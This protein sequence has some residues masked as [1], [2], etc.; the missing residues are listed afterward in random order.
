[1]SVAAA[2]ADVLFVDAGNC[3]GPGDGSELDP[4]C[5]IQTAIDNAVDA[6]EIVVAPGTYFEAIDYLGKSVAIRSSDGPEVTTIDG[7][8]FSSVVRCTHAQGPATALSGFVITGGNDTG[9]GGMFI[10]LSSPTVSDCTFIGNSAGV[11]GGM[12]NLVDSS[13][14]V[15]NCILWSDSPDEFGGAGTVTVSYSDVQGGFPGTGNIGADPLFVDPDNGD[16]RLQ[17]GSPCIDAGDNTAVPQGVL[18]DLDGNPRF[19]ADACAGDNGATVDMGAYE[20]QGTSCDLSD[21]LALLVAWGSC[22]DCGNCPS[23][24]DGDCSVGVFDLMILLADRSPR[25]SQRGGAR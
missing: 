4:Y 7:S 6:D 25:Q 16:Y 23:D 2:Q 11:G 5:S 15:T 18:R 13:L 20:F 19:V 24:H 8:G 1:M 14:T 17:P 22:K 10:L 21:T 9:G 3:P 12:F